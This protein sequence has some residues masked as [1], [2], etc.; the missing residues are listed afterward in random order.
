LR[1]E[2]SSGNVSGRAEFLEKTRGLGFG[3][4]G[5]GA[6]RGG[7]ETCSGALDA[8]HLKKPSST[9]L[10]TARAGSPLKKKGR[11]GGL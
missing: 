4:T 1:G 8:V 5:I 10:E 2:K 3:Y 9:E 11:I 7:G 6:P